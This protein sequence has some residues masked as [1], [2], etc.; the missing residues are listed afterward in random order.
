MLVQVETQERTRALA[1]AASDFFQHN[2]KVGHFGV[3][4]TGVQSICETPV[5]QVT[6]HVVIRAVRFEANQLD[7]LAVASDFGVD[8]SNYANEVMLVRNSV[9]GVV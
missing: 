9:I 4:V 1:I 5:R 2:P 8:R 3:G 6:K 7:L